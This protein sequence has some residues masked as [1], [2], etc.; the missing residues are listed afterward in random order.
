MDSAPDTMADLLD[1]FESRDI[2]KALEENGFDQGKQK[3][4]KERMTESYYER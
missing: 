1:S 3:E 4:L 2:R